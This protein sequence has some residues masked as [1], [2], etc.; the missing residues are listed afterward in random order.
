MTQ[1]DP[2]LPLAGHGRND[3]EE[4]FEY[5]DRT[6]YFLRNQPFY[7]EEE[8]GTMVARVHSDVEAAPVVAAV[9]AVENGPDR[10]RAIERKIDA[11]L[12]RMM[13]IESRLSSIDAALA[14]I[15]N[16]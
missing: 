5:G 11:M 4:P 14:R 8:F 12:A 13:S 9:D 15:L 7:V 3:V 10:D 6:L 1:D 2:T 16:R